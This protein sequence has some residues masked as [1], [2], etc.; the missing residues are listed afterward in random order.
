MKTV[1]TIFL[2][3]LS[4]SLA[5]YFIIR[6][7]QRDNKLEECLY[8]AGISADVDLEKYQNL[9]FKKYGK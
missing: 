8:G 7:I 2:M 9:C 1:V 5:Y 3:I 6:P 4:I